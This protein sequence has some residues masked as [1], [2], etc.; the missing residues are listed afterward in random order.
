MTEGLSSQLSS[1]PLDF[2]G[3]LVY[4]QPFFHQS[5][6]G[7]VAKEV[8]VGNPAEENDRTGRMRCPTSGPACQ[9]P[10]VITS[11]VQRTAIWQ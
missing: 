5:K 2:E 11:T 4:R 3:N 1:L 10:Y 6:P 8:G 9:V 7:T